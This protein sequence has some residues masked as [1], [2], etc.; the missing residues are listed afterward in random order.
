MMKRWWRR[1][2]V[3][4]AILVAVGCAGE[5]GTFFLDDTC[6]GTTFVF[7]PPAADLHVGDSVQLRARLNTQH[8]CIPPQPTRV[9]WRPEPP[10]PVSLRV[11]DDSTVVLTALTTG[12]V[13]LVVTQGPRWTGVLGVTIR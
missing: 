9:S 1:P 10:D 11:A 5:T 3:A 13:I 6:F 4:A 2:I 12:E 8:T 7:D